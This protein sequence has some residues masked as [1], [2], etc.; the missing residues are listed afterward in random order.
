MKFEDYSSCVVASVS[1]VKTTGKNCE[2]TTETVGFSLKAYA[3][4]VHV[5]RYLEKDRKN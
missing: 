2:T 1:E 3:R 5:C 4:T